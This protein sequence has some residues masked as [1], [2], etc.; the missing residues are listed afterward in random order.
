MVE[1]V[2]EEVVLREIGNVGRLYMRDVGGKQDPD[3]H[4]CVG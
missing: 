2:L 4:W 1:V 3:V